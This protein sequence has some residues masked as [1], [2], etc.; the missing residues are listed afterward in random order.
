MAHRYAF[1]SAL[2]AFALLAGAAAAHAAGG[3]GDLYVTSDASNVVRAYNGS[4]GAFIGV[5]CASVAP[6]SGQLS[7]HFGANNGRMLV[8]HFGGGVNEF[9]AA[10]GA[11]IKTYNPGGSWAWSAIYRPSGNVLMTDSANDQVLQF[12]GVTGA[13]MGTFATLPGGTL[14]SD[15]RYGPNGN[16]YVCGYG[17]STVFELHPTSGAIVGSWT[18]PVIGDRCNDIAFLPS[19]EILVTVMGSDV[20][21]RFDSTPVHNYLG[22]FAGTGWLRPHGIDV[23]PVNGHVFI[24][25]GVTMQVHE[26]HPTTF[27]ELTPAFLAPGPGDKI[28]DLEFRPAAGPTPAAPSSWG[29]LKTLYR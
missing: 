16:L 27:A 1:R 8:G 7:V 4:T 18:M 12:D 19:G 28:V 21:Y 14:P 23:S 6:A 2:L 24:A 10:T 13:L 3:I 22:S 20:C 15:M 11:F 25:D 17:N 5:H 9:D 29:R 26:F